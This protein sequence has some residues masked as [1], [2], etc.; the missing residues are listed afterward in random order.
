[1]HGVDTVSASLRRDFGER[2]ERARESHGG[3]SKRSDF[4]NVANELFPRYGEEGESLRDFMSR[5]AALFRKRR[6]NHDETPLPH[7]GKM[8]EAPKPVREE[9]HEVPEALQREI[10]AE[11]RQGHPE[12][13]KQDIRP[14]PADLHR[15]PA[16]IEV[17]GEVLPPSGTE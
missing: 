14:K 16:W 8:K 7:R 1:M 10:L 4:F 6:R 12:P 11:V 17:D 5:A 9:P 2:L 13:T 3:K 15:L